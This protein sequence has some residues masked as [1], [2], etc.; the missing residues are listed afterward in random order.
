MGHARWLSVLAGLAL[1]IPTGHLLTRATILTKLM[2]AGARQPL[3]RTPAD[4]GLPFEDITFSASDGIQL[5]GWFIPRAAHHRAPAIVFVHGWA[6][7]RIG[8]RAGSTII[9]DQT[10]DFLEVAQAVHNAG[11]H[12]LLFDLRNHGMSATAL[13]TTFGVNEARDLIGAIAWL[14]GH[15]AVDAEQIGVIGYSMGANTALFAL[16]QCPAIRVVVAVQPVRATTFMPRF[17]RQLLGPLGPGMAQLAVPL[18]RAFGAP[19]LTEIDPTTVVAQAGATPI[20]YIQG[21]GDTWGTLADIEAMT[22]RTPHARL[23]V[24]PSTERFGGYQY[25]N[26]HLHDIT[27]VF[28]QTL[29]PAPREVMGAK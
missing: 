14:Q 6:W 18:Y 16:P 17:A 22:A 2:I 11:F 4:V 27:D 26:A 24:A 21:S 5:S 25:I 8:N 3:W 7:N 23:I 20:V 19:P 9:P 13:P 29:L 10:I 15:A 28:T 1:G 12:V